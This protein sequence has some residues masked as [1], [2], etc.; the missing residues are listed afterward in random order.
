[1]F[2]FFKTRKEQVEELPARLKPMIAVNQHSP[3]P[4]VLP[5]IAEGIYPN[6]FGYIFYPPAE[7]GPDER[8]K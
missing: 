7:K 1:M 2:N 6:R 3:T 4:S 5:N 8:R